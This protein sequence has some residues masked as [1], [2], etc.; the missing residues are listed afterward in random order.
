METEGLLEIKQHISDSL[1]K[2][3]G[4]L[5]ERI[6]NEI[7]DEDLETLMSDLLSRVR[8]AAEVSRQ[9]LAVEAEMRTHRTMQEQ[10]VDGGAADAGALAGERADDAEA[11]LDTLTDQLVTLKGLFNV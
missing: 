6:E 8:A 5:M 4:D 7:S 9:L 10:L 2:G 1:E 3:V 11:R